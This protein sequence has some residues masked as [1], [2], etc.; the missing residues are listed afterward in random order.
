VT[1]QR[2]PV[3]ADFQGYGERI[4]LKRSQ[5][6][7][8]QSALAELVGVSRQTI[9]SMEAGGYAPSVF[10]ALRVAEALQTT[11]EALWAEESE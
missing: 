11:V 2:G 3:Q 9:I 7:L 10:L 1:R 8:S 6:S 5:L 4:K